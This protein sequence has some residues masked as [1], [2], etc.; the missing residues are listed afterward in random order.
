MIRTILSQIQTNLTDLPFVERYGGVVTAVTRIDEVNEDMYLEQRFPVSCSVTAI[1]CF[2]QGR[3]QD[4][5]P[6]DQY[7]SIFYF[8]EVDGMRMTR[9]DKNGN[10]Q[11]SGVVR[12]VGW[13]NLPKLGVENTCNIADQVAFTC[14]DALWNSYTLSAPIAGAHCEIKPIGMRPKSADIFSRYSYK[15]DSAHLLYP[16]DYFAFDFDVTLIM[17]AKCLDSFTP[18]TEIPCIDLS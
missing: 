16:Y 18:S 3:Y 12:L 14:V 4:L 10:L 2:E 7:K 6:N 5:V 13:L 9:P 11:M 15:N 17:R 1:Q 8:E